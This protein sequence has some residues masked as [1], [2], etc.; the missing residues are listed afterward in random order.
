M[1]TESAAAAIIAADAVADAADALLGVRPKAIRPILLGGNNRIYRLDCAGRSYA[2]KVYPKQDSDPRDRLGV[3]YE[4]LDFLARHGVESVPRPIA[5]DRA[6]HCAVYEWIEGERVADPGVAEVATLADFLGRLH[7]LR[8]AEGGERLRPASASCFSWTVMEEQV[9]ARRARFDPV[10]ADAP[11]LARFLRDRFDP[12]A[13]T[14]LDRLRRDMLGA[15]AGYGALPPERLTLS[16][17]DFGFHNALRRPDGGMVF[18][19]FEYFGWDDPVKAVSDVL[20][21]PGMDLSPAL[22][23]CFLDRVVPLYSAGDPGFLQRFD[24]LYPAFALSWCLILLNEFLPD[25]WARR[26][27]PGLTE[28]RALVL[29]RQLGKAERLH[30][31]IVARHGPSS[32]H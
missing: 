6:R 16:P 25:V 21:H 14:V 18:V 17:S 28:D 20:L 9:R 4:A 26:L 19:D 23:R 22:G 12:L 15:G 31:R 5:Y 8:R 10:M 27:R 7:G 13:A 30:Q 32:F 24:A 2:L 29:S 11:D 3:E 1:P